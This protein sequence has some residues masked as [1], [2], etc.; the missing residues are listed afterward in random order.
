MPSCS[1]AADST[2]DGLGRPARRL[3]VAARRAAGLG[4]RPGGARRG[5]GRADA[6]R[7][8]RPS[9]SSSSGAAHD[10]LPRR[11]GPGRSRADD[12]ARARADRR[13]RRDRLRPADPGRA[14]WTA[15]GRRASCCTPARRA[16]AHRSSQ[17]EI[18]RLLLEHG[19]AG[20]ECRAA[21]GRRPVRVRAR[22][23]GGRGAARRRR[24]VRGRARRHRRRR[25]TGV[26]RHPG[27]PSRR[28][29]RGRVR[30][31]PRGSRQAGVGARLGGARRVSRARSSSTWASALRG[32]RASG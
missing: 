5:G 2:L 25:R 7:G 9:C 24:P 28:G 10:R 3:G 11:R 27:H 6:G 13:R 19:A 20:R 1:T 4:E 23:R 26:R 22:R 21:Q 18:E 17:D 31:R 30:H 29:Q 16:A 8:R 15:R 12:R 14:R 32:D